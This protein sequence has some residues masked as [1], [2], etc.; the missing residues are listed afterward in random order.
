M[1]HVEECSVEKD[2]KSKEEVNVEA[3]GALEPTGATNW[4]TRNLNE[5][6]GFRPR[7]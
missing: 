5:V 2:N 3:A 4:S 1:N 7:G 6:E